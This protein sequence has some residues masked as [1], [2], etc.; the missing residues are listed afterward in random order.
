MLDWMSVMLQVH[1]EVQNI[2]M[3]SFTKELSFLKKIIKS[4]KPNVNIDQTV[5]NVWLK[6]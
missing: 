3:N 5:T 4:I 6:E 1:T 2:I